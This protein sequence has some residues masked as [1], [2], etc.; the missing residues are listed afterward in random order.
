MSSE[1]SIGDQCKAIFHLGREF[2]EDVDYNKNGNA[3]LPPLTTLF[4]PDNSDDEIAPT[5]P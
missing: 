5:S 1:D 2:Y 4:K 3:I